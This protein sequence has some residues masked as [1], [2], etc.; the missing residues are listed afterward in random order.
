MADGMSLGLMGKHFDC[1][2]RME[3]K[4]R[5]FGFLLAPA[6]ELIIRNK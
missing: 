5:V 3:F 4:Q 1:F 2:L 6:H